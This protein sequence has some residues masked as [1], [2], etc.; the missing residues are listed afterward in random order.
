MKELPTEININGLTY[1]S[2]FKLVEQQ[3][4]WYNLGLAAGKELGYKE[5]Y[6]EAEDK[7]FDKGYDMGHEMGKQ[8]T[9]SESVNDDTYQRVYMKGYGAGFDDGKKQQYIPLDVID[10]QYQKG[11]NDGKANTIIVSANRIDEL[12]TEWYELGKADGYENGYNDGYEQKKHD[13]IS[14]KEIPGE[15]LAKMEEE[16]DRGYVN[17]YEECEEVTKI[18]HKYGKDA[19]EYRKA[20]KEGFNH[21]LN[22]KIEE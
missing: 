14:E 16:Y 4:D 21:A 1:Y 19:D 15:Y 6:A 13:G 22:L 12:K 8:C 9:L 17:G 5:G 2:A 3:L 18:L 7:E 11:Y 20:Y 10:N